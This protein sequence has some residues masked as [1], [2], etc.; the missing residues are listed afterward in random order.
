MKGMTTSTQQRSAGAVAVSKANGQEIARGSTRAHSKCNSSA[1]EQEV[2]LLW[3]LWDTADHSGTKVSNYYKKTSRRVQCG[4]GRGATTKCLPCKP[5]DLGS[6]PGSGG[7]F[8]LHSS[9]VTVQTFK[10]FFR[11]VKI[12]ITFCYGTCKVLVPEYRLAVL[13]D[14]NSIFGGHRGIEKMYRR[15]RERCQCKGMKEDVHDY[16]CRCEKCQEQ[17]L[18]RIKTREP[19]VI[20]DIPSE[21]FHKVAINTVGPLCKTTDG[22]MYILTMECQFSKFCIA[23][24]IPN[25]KAITI[26]DALTRYLLAQHGSNGSLERS[27]AVL[28]DFLRNKA[29]CKQDWDKVIPFAMHEYNT[30]IHASTSFTPFELVKTKNT[31]IKWLKL[32]VGEEVLKEPWYEELDKYYNGQFIM[33]KTFLLTLIWLPRYQGLDVETPPFYE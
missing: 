22:N 21:I 17:K 19:M 16:V 23:V 31:T 25:I 5:E 20:T 10:N 1:V 26:A 3:C 4:G 27:H 29:F 7:T 18:V 28:A 32:E 8:S 2:A 15:I 9:L 24:P 6:S 14:Y 13:E 33:W 30:S 12:A 11:N